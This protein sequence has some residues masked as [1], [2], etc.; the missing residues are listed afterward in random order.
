MTE[1]RGNSSLESSRLRTPEIEALLAI[2]EKLGASHDLSETF[3]QIMEILAS[4]FGM[5]RG[6]LTL[7]DPETKELIIR[8]AHGL[9]EEEMKRG[10]Y[11]IGEGI[12]GKVVE[13]RGPVIVPSIGREP[14]FLDRTGARKNI[15]RDMIA[16]L[17]VPLKLQNEVMG[18]LSVDKVRSSDDTLESD[19][20]FL[21]IIASM[22]A[23]AVRVHGA[24]SE[25][26][27]LKE[28]TDRILAG[29]PEGVLVL[30]PRGLV[31]ALNPA[32]EQIFGLKRESVAGKL[33][34]DVFN[35]FQ[36]VLNIIER[37]YDDPGAAPSFETQIFGVAPD[38]VPVL[39]TWSIVCDEANAIQ[40]IV[41]NVQD[42]TDVKRLERQ[43]RRNQRLA[44]LG[45]MAAGVAHE[46]R[47]PLGCIRGASQLLLREIQDD[48][49]VRDFLDVI[50][51]EVDRLDRTVKQLL[52][53]ARPSK[54]EMVPT[55]IIPVMERALELVKPD[56]E[57]GGFQI[58]KKFP[59]SV[60]LIR[61][62][63]G[64]L[65]QVF[66]NLFLN[67]L[68]AMPGGGTL[69]ITV[70]VDAQSPGSNRNVVV[71]DISDTGCGMSAAALEQLFTP[72]FTTREEGTG[73]GLALSHRIIEEHRAT[74][75]VMSRE[76]IGTT[77]SI[78][79]RSIRGHI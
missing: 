42:L 51:K 10:K 61:A 65:T 45:T 24:I 57:R 38:P 70:T 33:Y 9:T 2:S 67:A 22:I 23:Q 28:R 77:F 4:R 25:V 58:I 78:S 8:V 47:N 73:L 60:P 37:I 49:R 18:V 7:L 3:Q 6:T 56:I 46:I 53:F 43:S 69:S 76:G 16:F 21:T 39:F 75:D 14:L 12:T 55:N 26:V 27:S 66:L 36:N 40:A 79:F 13:L 15:D 35:R 64:Q 34:L 29:M 52:D 48:R 19:M 50:I 63:G 68:Q 72:F 41:V 71:V 59:P 20:R 54:T 31:Q 32:A 17:C 1:T 5:E 30:D 11:K 62:D 74:I 44:S